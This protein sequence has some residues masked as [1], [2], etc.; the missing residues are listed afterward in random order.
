MS[1]EAIAD[2]LGLGCILIGSVM[3]LTSSIGLVRLRDLY[4]RMH[5]GAKP[6]ALGVLL[7]LLGMGLRLRSGLDIGMLVLVGIFQMMTIPVSAHLVSRA[8]YRAEPA[9]HRAESAD[10]PR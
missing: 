8:R 1:W 2:G 6:Q 7:V 3:C 4:S 9:D 10:H 5:A